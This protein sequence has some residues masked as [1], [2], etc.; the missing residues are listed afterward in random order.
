MSTL[1]NIHVAWNLWKENIPPNQIALRCNINRATAYRWIARFKT[2]GLKRTI[3]LKRIAHK[4]KRKRLDPLIKLRIYTLRDKHKQ[5]C[6]QKVQRYLKKEYGHKVSLATIYRVLRSRYKLS[7]RYKPGRDYGQVPK[8]DCPRDVIQADTVNFGEIYA[9]TFIDTFTREVSVVIRPTL[10]SMD[11]RI[12]LQ[13]AMKSFQMVNLLQTDGGP[14]FE[15]EFIPEVKV[16]AKRHRVSRPYKKNEQSYIESFN[17]T[18]RKEC[19][20][21]I[22]Y[23]KEEIDRLQDKVNKYL[24]YYHNERLHIG[25]NYQ[26][27]RKYLQL[28]SHLT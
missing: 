26:T 5:C 7:S 8:A 13:E 12:A 9:Y 14:E 21:W 6:G 11:G 16:Y 23:R 10:E 19:L 20:G 4:R 15:K 25:L 28:L 17:R 2:C 18:L 27:P 1:T 24:E 22:K 3:E